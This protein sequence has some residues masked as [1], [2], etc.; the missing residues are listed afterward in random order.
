MISYFQDPNQP[1]ESP[2]KA[3]YWH[4]YGDVCPLHLKPELVGG[5]LCHH[6]GG[7]PKNKAH[8][9]DSRAMRQERPS[10][11]YCLNTWIQKACN[12]SVLLNNQVPFPLSYFELD[13]HRL[14]LHK[15]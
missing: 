5:H 1:I 6:F 15:G 10:S 3:F 4:Y 12:F 11:G 13:F 7:P 9:R 2:L 8:I 14:Q